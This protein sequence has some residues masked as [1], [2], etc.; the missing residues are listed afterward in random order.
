M[1]SIK[2]KTV[3]NE[4]RLWAVERKEKELAPTFGNVK[5]ENEMTQRSGVFRWNHAPNV[6]SLRVCCK[7]NE[8][9]KR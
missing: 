7:I 1:R 2:K 3:D 6:T 4:T 8:S 9:P 5:A